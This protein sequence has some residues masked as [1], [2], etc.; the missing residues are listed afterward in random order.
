MFHKSTKV[1]NY[2]DLIIKD[3]LNGKNNEICNIEETF[4]P[5]QGFFLINYDIENENGRVEV[6]RLPFDFQAAAEVS[7][8][9]VNHNRIHLVELG[10]NKDDCVSPFVSLCYDASYEDGIEYIDIKIRP[11]KYTTV[12]GTVSK[13]K[14]L[15]ILI[16]LIATDIP[17][18][19]FIVDEVDGM[20]E[21]VV[22]KEHEVHL[23]EF[24][25][26]V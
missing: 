1:R 11:D 16:D 8:F 7:I 13:V 12:R 3:F 19:F 24:K 20:Y 18:A 9:D 2:G 26:V 23:V 5:L 21:I 25:M 10:K 14:I 4:E 15:Q 6:R 22:P 17:H